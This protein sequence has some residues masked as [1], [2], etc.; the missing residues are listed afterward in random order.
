LCGPWGCTAPLEAIA[1]C[2]LAWLVVLMPLLGWSAKIVSPSRF[3]Q[4]ALLLTAAGAGGIAV[5]VF[6][7]VHQAGWNF[8]AP[9]LW[10]RVGLSVVGATDVPILAVLVLGTL[11][12]GFRL[13]QRCLANTDVHHHSGAR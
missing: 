2:H 12:L 1:A 9:Y 4:T 7:E 3:T 10:H 6:R 13:W 11:A 5:L 8:A